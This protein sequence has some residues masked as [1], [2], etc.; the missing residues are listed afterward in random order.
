MNRILTFLLTQLI[1]S[2]NSIPSPGWNDE[3]P[4]F[5]GRRNTWN[6]NYDVVSDNDSFE[7]SWTTNEK[8]NCRDAR[9]KSW[10]DEEQDFNYAFGCPPSNIDIR[11]SK[12]GKYNDD[13]KLSISVIGDWGGK[14]FT[15]ATKEAMAMAR[16]VDKS[17]SPE[18]YDTDFI[19]LV[20][21]NFYEFGVKSAYDKKWQLTWQTIFKKTFKNIGNLD[22]FQGSKEKNTCACLHM[23]K[24]IL[25]CCACWK[26]FWFYTNFYTKVLVTYE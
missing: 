2:L 16:D 26:I 14:Y 21:D 24:A 25:V 13:Q 17:A 22:Y 9:I 15:Y 10:N 8:I 19:F 20:G 4:H 12:N 23:C 11:P 5:N 7:D 18:N 3:D 1:S 6:D